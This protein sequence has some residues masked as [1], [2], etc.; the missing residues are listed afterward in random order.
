MGAVVLLL[1]YRYVILAVRILSL[2]KLSP[3]FLLLFD[4]ARVEIIV[5]CFETTNFF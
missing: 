5:G 1:F 3:L 4:A 2:R